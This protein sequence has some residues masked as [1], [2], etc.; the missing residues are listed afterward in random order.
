MWRETSSFLW[1]IFIITGKPLVWSLCLFLVFYG[2]MFWQALKWLVPSF[3]YLIKSPCF[4]GWLM[5]SRACFWALKKQLSLL[6]FLEAQKFHTDGDIPFPSPIEK[7]LRRLCWSAKR[8]N[9]ATTNSGNNIPKT[10][11]ERGL[12]A[13]AAKRK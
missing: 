9:E 11:V 7:L 13:S 5:I 4:F 12:G 2:L 10:K 1:I 3:M 8:R 6:L